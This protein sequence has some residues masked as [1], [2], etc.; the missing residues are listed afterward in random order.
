MHIRPNEPQPA[1]RGDGTL[2]KVTSGRVAVRDFRR[3][4]TIVL[5]AKRRYLARAK[6]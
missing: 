3:K 5:R 6:R 2:T 1:V 4:K